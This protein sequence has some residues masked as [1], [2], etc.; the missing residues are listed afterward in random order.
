MYISKYILS[1]NFRNKKICSKGLALPT[2]HG[3]NPPPPE[4]S[5]Q[6]YLS[7]MEFTTRDKDVN[8]IIKSHTSLKPLWRVS[9]TCFRRLLI[10]LSLFNKSL[11]RSVRSFAL[12]RAN[13]LFRLPISGFFISFDFW[14][15]ENTGT[16][17][18][19]LF[20]KLVFTIK[21]PFSL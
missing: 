10:S 17:K 19:I 21:K 5:F 15:R 8:N 9:S 1:Q 16:I 20:G 14:W 12:C 18:I 13:A 4:L 2:K 7:S 6:Y 11:A 3:F